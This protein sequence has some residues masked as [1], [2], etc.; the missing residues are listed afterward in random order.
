MLDSNRIERL[1]QAL[2]TIQNCKKSTDILKTT[3]KE[4]KSLISFSNC[5][6]FVMNPDLVSAVMSYRPDIDHVNVATLMIENKNCKSVCEN[7]TMATP[8]FSKID[9]VRYGLKNQTHLAHPVI[10][11]EDEVLFVIQCESR[12]IK[13]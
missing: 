7:D 1:L 8:S 5:T 9:E 2:N 10:F 3:L 4:L 6:I 11:R 13:R 12:I